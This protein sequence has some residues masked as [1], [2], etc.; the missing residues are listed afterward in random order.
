MAHLYIMATRISSKLIPNAFFS[1]LLLPSPILFVHFI[2][3]NY[4]RG[5]KKIYTYFPQL[6]LIII[7]LF[8]VLSWYRLK[9]K[10]AQTQAMQWV[11]YKPCKPENATNVDNEWMGQVGYWKCR[12]AWVAWAAL[13]HPTTSIYCIS[14]GIVWPTFH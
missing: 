7:P 11:V 8:W 5:W 12:I 3:F 9:Y 2:K 14:L 13:L 1:S 6:P 10:H 4:L